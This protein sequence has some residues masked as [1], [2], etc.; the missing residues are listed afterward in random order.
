MTFSSSQLVAQR[1]CLFQIA[2]LKP[3]GEPA[4]DRSEKLASL[5]LL[6]LVSPEPR[7]AHGGAEFPGLR[8]LLTR[9]RERALEIR[10]CFHGIALRRD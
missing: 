9:D 4:V 3:L 6:S 7:N 8:L 2:R 1:F 10:F 5:I